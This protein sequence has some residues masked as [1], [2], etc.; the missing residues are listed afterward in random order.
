MFKCHCAPCQ[1]A[2]AKAKDPKYWATE[3]IWGN[4]KKLAERLLAEGVPGFVTQMAYGFYRGV[5]DF[6][7][8]TNVMVMVA[9]EGAWATARQTECDRF[10]FAHLPLYVFSQIA[11]DNS[12]DPEA[13]IAEYL[14]LMFGAGAKA[15]GEYIRIQE[16][17]WT[18]KI[19]GRTIVTA[20]GPSVTPP[21][22]YELWNKVYSKKVADRL[23]PL[24]DEAE[25]AVPKNSLKARRV[26]LYR[27]ET[28]DPLMARRGDDGFRR[29]GVQV[30]PGEAPARHDAVD[31]PGL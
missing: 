25:A 19:V 14:R 8:P 16:Y 15:M 27:A 7:L 30:P 1:A 6:S 29:L 31:P 20:F 5:P 9:E 11:W 24:L 18:K 22:E 4:T 13:I 17:A 2:Y 10:F 3:L 23:A 12:A 21:T 26:A 28:F